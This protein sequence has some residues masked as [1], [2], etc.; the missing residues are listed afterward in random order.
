MLLEL[1]TGRRHQARAHLAWLNTPLIGDT[2]YGEDG[3][4][5]LLLH[6]LR[7]DLSAAFPEERPVYAPIPGRF[8]RAVENAADVLRRFGDNVGAM[9]G[10]P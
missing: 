2:V 3:H 5:G 9:N 8:L 10:G 1:R 7:L 6:A 4:H